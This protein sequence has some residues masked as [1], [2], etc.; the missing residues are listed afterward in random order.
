MEKEEFNRSINELVN[1]INKIKANEKDKDA[2]NVFTALKLNSSSS[3]VR[4]CSLLGAF[5]NIKGGSPS[6][7]ES[8]FADVL[9]ER[10]LFNSADDWEIKLEYEI[11]S[12]K[13]AKRRVD[14]MILSQT[15]KIYIP[16]EVKLYA[17]D[18]EAQIDDNI[19]YLIRMKSINR[20]AYYLTLDGHEPS[21]ESCS[22]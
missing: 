12:K 22:I 8:F 10:E 9:E 20:N 7:L 15:K 5:L 6:F 2:F 19:D 13:Q 21:E 17:G 3:E 11:K 1:E 14:I 4:I 16:I 18:S